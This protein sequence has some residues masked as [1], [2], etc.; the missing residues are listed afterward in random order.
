MGFE[1]EVYFSGVFFFFNKSRRE[2][3]EVACWGTFLEKKK[4]IKEK[5][6]KG[7]ATTFTIRIVL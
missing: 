7:V 5:E 3:G 1:K 6:K 4:E 2:G